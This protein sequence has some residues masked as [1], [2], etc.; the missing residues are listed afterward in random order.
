[1]SNLATVA[2]AVLVVNLPFGFWRAGVKRFTLRWFLA[3]HA[4]VP[5]V[6]GLRA[7]LGLGWRLS[8]VPVLAG[9]FFA[10]QFL[11]GRLRYWWEKRRRAARLDS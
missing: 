11:G 7:L 10:G 9:A 6:V 4:P 3:I 2:V 8:T 1:M 5:V